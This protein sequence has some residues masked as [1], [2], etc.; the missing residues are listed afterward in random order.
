M[1]IKYKTI[2]YDD[3]TPITGIPKL[4]SG[5][6]ATAASIGDLNDD[7][8]GMSGFVEYTGSGNYY[9]VDAAGLFTILRPGK[10][11]ISGTEITWAG[12]EHVHLTANKGYFIGYTATDTLA[13][14][15]VSTIYSASPQ[16][17]YE[18]FHNALLTT[19]ILYS[20]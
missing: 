1:A 20:V 17:H 18:N 13:A 5:P 2:V 10:G 3:A 14:I 19:V 6:L 16:T 8:L 7:A 11:R 9:S 12:N 4:A 15:D